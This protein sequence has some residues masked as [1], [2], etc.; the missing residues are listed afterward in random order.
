MAELT[1]E[2]LDLHGFRYDPGVY[3]QLCAADTVG[4]FQVESRA[5][6]SFL[7]RLRPRNLADTAIS[8]GALAHAVG[9]ND[10]WL[11]RIV[12]RVNCFEHSSK[13]CR[14]VCVVCE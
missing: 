2:R 6:Q 8:V 5:Q 12:T 7:P 11:S 3:D 9:K 1:G 14:R 13:L 10:C 4:L